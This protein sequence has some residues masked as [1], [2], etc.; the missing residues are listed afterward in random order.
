ML[1]FLAAP[2]RT[3]FISAELGHQRLDRDNGVGSFMGRF[4]VSNELFRDARLYNY[5]LAIDRELAGHAR[6]AG[7]PRCGGLLDSATYPR[8]PR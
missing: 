2:T 5:L 1:V 6:R 7:C 3:R 8:K 4:N